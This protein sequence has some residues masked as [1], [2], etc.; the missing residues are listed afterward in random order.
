MAKGKSKPKKKPAKKKVVIKKPATKKAAK[1]KP[2]KK[3]VVI[4]KPVKKAA[5]KK[6]AGIKAATKKKA[7]QK[8]GKTVKAK[9]KTA[10][11]KKHA[12]SKMARLTKEDLD[13]FKRILNEKR[14]RIIEKARNTL[15]EGMKLDEA[16]LPD[17]YDMAS[18]EYLQYFTLRLR[19]RERYFLDKIDKALA[20]IDGGAFGIC[21]L[22]GDDI[23]MARLMARPETTLCIRC[24]E[25]QEREERMFSE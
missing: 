1:K 3:K 21:E 18:S 8:A 5:K 15:N 17:E 20:R 9:G 24:K 7:A 11:K 25:T 14:N 2:A 4:K 22:C 6:P 16:D 19:G 12:S 23:G 10:K 13:Y